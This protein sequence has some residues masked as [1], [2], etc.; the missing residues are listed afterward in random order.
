MISV[1]TKNLKALKSYPIFNLNTH[2]NAN[3]DDNDDDG[4][5]HRGLNYSPLGIL[6]PSRTK[7]KPHQ[8]YWPNQPKRRLIEIF[9]KTTKKWITFECLEISA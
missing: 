6:I 4:R 3:H 9:Q 7:I 5:H 2:A 8:V 1:Y